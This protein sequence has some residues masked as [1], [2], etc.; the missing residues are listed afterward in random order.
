LDQVVGKANTWQS[1]VSEVFGKDGFLSNMFGAG[2]VN[3]GADLFGFGGL[4]ED[5]EAAKRLKGNLEEIMTA[6]GSR[7]G[8]LKLAIKARAEELALTRQQ[9]DEIWAMVRASD[10]GQRRAAQGRIDAGNAQ[11]GAGT[12]V[13]PDL[14]AATDKQLKLISQLYGR[15]TPQWRDQVSRTLDAQVKAVRRTWTRNG[16]LTREGIE[17][18]KDIQ[19]RRKNLL[20]GSDPIGIGKGIVNSWKKARTATQVN[21]GRMV[22]QLKELPPK[23]R[24]QAGQ[25]MLKYAKELENKGKLPE[26]TVKRLRSKIMLQFGPK[27]WREM[28]AD[29]SRGWNGIFQQ[30]RSGTDRTAK[31]MSNLSSAA[32]RHSRNVRQSIGSLAPSA[33]SAYSTLAAYSNEAAQAFGSSRSVDLDFY[34][35]GGETPFRGGKAMSPAMVSSGE[36]VESGGKKWRV[37][38]RPVAKDNVF[39][40]LPERAKV[41]TFD[42]QRRLAEGESK[43]SA[44][45]N[46]LPHFGSGGVNMLNPVSGLPKPRLSGGNPVATSTGQAAIDGVRQAAVQWIKKYASIPAEIRKMIQYGD[47]IASKGLPYQY[48][49]GHGQ[50][51]V[52]TPSFDCSGFV[53]GI[54]GAGGF[55]SSPMAVAQGTGLYTLGQAGTGKFH[56]WG[57]RGSSGMDAH[58][59]I[60]VQAGGKGGYYE[61]GGDGVV[62]RSSWNG[63]FSHRH[64]PGFRDGGM[65][66]KTVKGSATWFAGGATAGGSDTSKPGVSLNPG[67]W[68]SPITRLWRDS[69]LAGNPF[70]ARVKVGGRSAVLPIT[71]MGPADWT[72]HAIDVTQGGLAKLGFSTS[73][74][75]S[76]TEGSATILGTSGMRKDAID[77]AQR[78]V[79]GVRKMWASI[80]K[81][82]TTKAGR[83]RANL[84]TRHALKAVKAAKNWN[85][86]G[87]EDRIRRSR[88][89]Q[90]GAYQGIKRHV[91]QKGNNGGGRPGGGSGGGG[92]G[93]TGGGG[94]AGKGFGWTKGLPEN[95]RDLIRTPGL[96]WQQRRDLVDNA[97]ETAQGTATTADD[98]AAYDVILTM[99]RSRKKGALSRFRKSAGRFRKLGGNGRIAQIRKMLKNGD[100]SKQKRKQLQNEL[101]RLQGAKT[102]RDDALT[103]LNESSSAIQSAKEGKKSLQ[104]QQQSDSEADLA[105]AI[106]DLNDTIAEQNRIQSGVAAVGQREAMRMLADVLGGQ[107]VGKGAFTQPQGVRY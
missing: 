32:R 70:Y 83:K 101:A 82:G 81:H 28:Q 16:R 27:L 63:S 31:Q 56:E 35:G 8:R 6:E 40:Y 106:K 67:T 19:E 75:P 44:L 76:G 25:T 37:P 54:L 87:A 55:I 65:I 64:M 107:M 58:T 17:R 29:T 24:E 14:Q 12:F 88:K 71:D 41:W 62:K 59:M 61:A 102:R 79:G 57:V 95:I 33:R 93:S 92:G 13:G 78:R 72:G 86:A 84:A 50:I 38:G 66:G 34:R 18:I 85:I 23:A 99:E 2:F 68:N 20:A 104:E 11:I 48:G 30:F 46:Q 10:V 47:R 100:L 22:K 4:N 97:L 39:A 26:G 103:T 52:G 94:S 98:K 69:S 90:R 89:Q 3:A 1:K 77:K 5:A 36:V 42:G 73:N 80:K 15:Y 53:S 96:S 9:K 7:F 51:G 49:G 74:F 91:R 105:A 21:M 43:Q 60:R 45:R